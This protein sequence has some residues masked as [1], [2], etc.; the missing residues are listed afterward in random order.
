M[1]QHGI[2]LIKSTEVNGIELY[3]E[4]PSTVTVTLPRPFK[5]KPEDEAY[6]LR[7]HALGQLYVDYVKQAGNHYPFDNGNCFKSKNDA[8]AWLDAMKEVVDE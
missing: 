3:Q 4:K 1:L 5:P 7:S 6:F 8:Q 2:A